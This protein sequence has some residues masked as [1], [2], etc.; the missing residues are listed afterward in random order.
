MISLLYPFVFLLGMV[1]S[2][3]ALA[4]GYRKVSAVL[5][6]L[7][8]ALDVYAQCLPLRLWRMERPAAPEDQSVLAF[9][10]HGSG[11][12]YA[13]NEQSIASLVL[14]QDAD[15]IL[16]NDYSENV[17]SDTLHNR[18]VAAGY[19][20][21]ARMWESGTALY[22]RT[23]AEQNV[24]DLAPTLGGAISLIEAPADG[25]EPDIYFCHLASNNYDS[26]GH[27]YS[28]PDSI[29][30]LDGLKFYLRRGEE[31]SMVRRHVAEQLLER[32]EETDRPTI[33]IGDMNDVGGSP[34]MN[35]IRRHGFKDAWW[36]GGFGY[37]ATFHDPLPFRI[38]HIFYNSGLRL[39]S[40]RRISARSLSDHD[41]VL[42][43][44][45]V[46]GRK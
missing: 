30:S 13:L 18:I 2:L 46:R 17:N 41:A 37:G 10:V 44:F 21:L 19:E 39:L 32:V 45:E 42:A 27:N 8:L 3:V 40:V 5:L 20:C 14:E 16:L 33:I 4:L 34:A 26:T 11:E 28:T 25:T 15:I 6:A 7:S 12:S 24:S 1:L 31:A 43:R 9:N 29:R 36:Q 22:S 35:A 38:D 23:G